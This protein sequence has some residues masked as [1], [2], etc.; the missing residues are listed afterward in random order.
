M[1]ARLRELGRGLFRRAA[2]T[3]RR[4]ACAPQNED[5]I[6]IYERDGAQETSSERPFHLS[7]W[8]GCGA[9]EAIHD[10]GPQALFGNFFGHDEV[11]I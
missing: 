11:E 7:L 4:A 9:A 1:E 10:G 3:R 8:L 6:A 2:E 5:W